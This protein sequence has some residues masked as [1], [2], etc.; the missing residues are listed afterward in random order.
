MDTTISSWLF[1]LYAL[2]D[3]RSITFRT[4]LEF[5]ADDTSSLPFLVISSVK[6]LVRYNRSKQA[7][8]LLT[9]NFIA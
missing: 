4:K 3:S 2:G 9:L 1:L 8:T 7:D 5:S 6:I